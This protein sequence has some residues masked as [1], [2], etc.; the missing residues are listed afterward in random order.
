[1]ENIHARFNRIT[2]ASKFS[3]SLSHIFSPSLPF[4]SS[5]KKQPNTAEDREIFIFRCFALKAFAKW[6]LFLCVGDVFHCMFLRLSVCAYVCV[7]L[8]ITL[9]LKEKQP[10]HSLFIFICQTV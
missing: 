2:E 5:G 8:C 7:V 10:H 1:M 6:M 3:L 9:L 4:H